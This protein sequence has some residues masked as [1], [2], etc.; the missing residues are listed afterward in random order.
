[1]FAILC[2]LTLF[3]FAD[4]TNRASAEVN[5]DEYS[6]AIG[7]N[8]DINF[9]INPTT[10]VSQGGALNVAK[11]TIIGST[12]APTGYR[13]FLSSASDDNSFLLEG[14]EKNTARDDSKM[15]AT[16][17]TFLAPE[18][19]F[20]SQDTPA[21]WGFAIPGVGSFD[22]VYTTS[23]P[24]V[25]AKFAAV[26]TAGNGQL[27][28][29]TD[30]AIE[31]DSLDIYY[32]TKVNSRLRH[33]K[34]S[35]WVKYSAITDMSSEVVDGISI[36][37]HRVRNNYEPGTAITI[38]SEARIASDLGVLIAT[39]NNQTCGNIKKTSDDP[40]ILT[41]EI[42]EG[43]EN[44]EYD[45][46]LSIPQY[47]KT[48]SSTDKLKIVDP[49]DVMQ[50]I[51]KEVYDSVVTE[52][53]YQF[54]DSRD[55]KKYYITKLKNGNLYMTQNLDFEL[56]TEGTVLDPETSDVETTKTLT[57]NVS[58]SIQYTTSEKKY[59]YTQNLDAEGRQ[60]GLYENNW[61]NS[62]IR[63]TGRETGS[64]Q[65]HVVTIPG[66]A[67]LLIDIY[68]SGEDGY[69]WFGIFKGSHP[70][71]NNPSYTTIDRVIY[72]DVGMHNGTSYIVNGNTLEDVGHTAVVVEGDTAT[73]TFRA[74]SNKVGNGYGYY[75]IISGIM[76][77][78]SNEG[79]PND[80]VYLKV[81][82]DENNEGDHHPFGAL[83]SLSAAITQPVAEDTAQT[84]SICPKG[85]HLDNYA[86]Y[87]NTITGLYGN[88]S[89]GNGTMIMKSSPLFL[90]YG[91]YWGSNY[92]SISLLGNL[93]TTA[94]TAENIYN[95]MIEEGKN[96]VKFIRCV[97]QAPQHY[98]ISFNANGGSNPP[99]E[100]YFGGWESAN[101]HTFVLG[102]SIPMREDGTFKG[103]S[104]NANALTGDYQPGDKFIATGQHT[105][106]AIWG[107]IHNRFDDAFEAAGKTKMNGYYAMQDMTNEICDAVPKLI[108]EYEANTTQLIDLRDNKIYFVSKLADGKCWMTQNLNYELSNSGTTLD[109]STSSVAT[110]RT[111]LPSDFGEDQTYYQNFGNIMVND[112][113]GSVDITNVAT[114]TS[115]PLIHYLVG[116]SYTYPAATALANKTN[117]I[118][119]SSS[120]G[121]EESGD[122]EY[123]P[124][125]PEEPDSFAELKE[126]AVP[127][128]VRKYSHTQNIDDTGRASGNYGNSWNNSYIRGTDRT[129]AN[130]NAHVITI[131][132]ATELNVE[133]YHSG[134]SCCDYVSVYEGSHPTYT[135][136]TSGYKY[137]QAMGTGSNYGSYS[138]N[139]NT[140]NAYHA[141]LTI[142]GDT[143]TFAFRSDSSVNGYGYYAIVT[144][145][146][147]G[148][149]EDEGI[150]NYNPPIDSPVE[151]KPTAISRTQNVDESGIKTTGYSYG[152]DNN[153]IAGTN[154]T[155]NSRPHAVCISN[156]DYLMVDIYYSM[157]SSTYL[158]MLG[159]D[160]SSN[161]SDWDILNDYYGVRGATNING[162]G[163]GTYTI[164]GNSISNL[165]YRRFMV[166]G[167]CVSFMFKSYDNGSNYY[168]Y[169][170]IVYGEKISD[171]TNKKIGTK[172]SY[173]SNL[174]QDGR[175]N[176]NYGDNWGNA[177]ILGSTR[178]DS[179]NAHVVTIPN[180]TKLLVDIFYNTESADKDWVSV[181][182][183][184]QGTY[185]A[186]RNFGNS[187]SGKLGGVQYGNYT[188]KNHT[189]SN[190]GHKQYIISGNSV[191]F[192]FTSNE[193]LS[194]DGYG[195]YAI[196]TGY[197]KN[198]GSSDSVTK[199]A[200]VQES[201][202][203]KGW[204]LPHV[205]NSSNNELS[206]LIP[207][208]NY[209]DAARRR[210][211]V[212]QPLF[213][214][215][216]EAP[217]N[218]INDNSIE[219]LIQTLK[220]T[221]A[222]DNSSLGFVRCIAEETY[223]F[224][225]TFNT[226]DDGAVAPD[227]V[228]A[229][230]TDYSEKTIMIPNQDIS[231]P[232][233]K[234]LG[235]SIDQN[236]ESATYFP[237]T[238]YS[239]DA[240]SIELYAVWQR[241]ETFDEAFEMVGKTKV[242]GE[243]YAMQDMTEQICGLIPAYNGTIITETLIDTRDNKLYTIAKLKDNHCWM[244]Q[245]LAFMTGEGVTLNPSTSDVEKEMSANIAP[246]VNENGFYYTYEA[247]T[248]GFGRGL[249]TMMTGDKLSNIYY[250]NQPGDSMN[251]IC[252]KGWS[253]PS[254]T[255]QGNNYA[256]LINSYLNSGNPSML[257]TDFVPNLNGVIDTST[258][259]TISSM[260]G[261]WT[262]T[263]AQLGKSI[264]VAFT[265]NNPDIAIS[266]RNY[267]MPIR[268]MAVDDSSSIHIRTNLYNLG[269]MQGITPELVAAGGFA[270]DVID[271]RDE[272][273][274]NRPVYTV[275][276]AYDGRAW[277][278][279]SLRYEHEDG[280]I[281][282]PYTSDV[283]EPIAFSAE[284]PNSYYVA[285][286]HN[287]YYAENRTTIDEREIPSYYSGETT[288]RFA[289]VYDYNTSTM[290]Y[291]YTF[292]YA[293]VNNHDGSSICPAGWQLPTSDM[294]SQY[295]GSGYSYMTNGS[296]EGL[297]MDWN[298]M[299]NLGGYYTSPQG[300]E[301][302]D[303][304]HA[305]D[306]GFFWTSTRISNRN[307][308]GMWFSSTQSNA[309]FPMA[310][311]V[312]GQVRCVSK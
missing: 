30:A 235:W 109:P 72:S 163:T 233:H 184:S 28:H 85:W 83:Y 161:S 298:Q 218:Y 197:G 296:S 181:W 63:G 282:D 58:S 130:S 164:N 170:A 47:G 226:N 272:G 120:S 150:Q 9:T 37:P 18:A 124:E 175:K 192:S 132:G 267:A 303:P 95:A 32:G 253:I 75:A 205:V 71:Y 74:D 43:L 293:T 125:D 257:Q 79:E 119:N 146:T 200:V 196:I 182:S 241:I 135:Q 141:T 220:N 144:A 61:N 260:S 207:E 211:F 198:N 243:H 87:N 90:E 247:A 250:I 25:S 88:T 3:P 24:S 289:D 201:V 40:L 154:R 183:G 167:T 52:Q 299:M 160:E 279:T 240:A 2:L 19:L 49:Y 176:A 188:I 1:M 202:C 251:T 254:A 148:S 73:F 128:T 283:P 195:Y 156:V 262:T 127:S 278:T 139:G 56:S 256:G 276:K 41:C 308:R 96:P 187:L 62:H 217:V 53:Q 173:T 38:T 133:L 59:S 108:S 261:Y 126:G 277:M 225:M 66:A 12:N 46:A 92:T 291:Y 149:Y 60:L 263:L 99:E 104:E 57:A 194:G 310:R 193:N 242:D 76:V 252:P 6:L 137:N 236:A 244:I 179:N 102:K 270:E 15:Q 98:S 305:G 229:L 34:Y 20:T 281:L 7:M 248:A 11:T 204:R 105:L 177:N 231:Y 258:N 54:V 234:F 292:D 93:T 307:A 295:V 80:V 82:E 65:G 45:V 172:Y 103:W 189:L 100:Q 228:Y 246:I 190:M 216:T 106:Y 138:L 162:V 280:A 232:G 97:Y 165:N 212:E 171:S 199:Q 51:D 245:D 118:F 239:F 8:G 21:T 39:V 210:Y 215:D 300:D 36:Y 297:R 69:D 153:N 221:Y 288:G 208:G 116:S 306:E 304:E 67:A 227:N 290:G 22:D 312:A 174:D 122:H 219:P 147:I 166:T 42:P 111:I 311:N 114:S 68:H 223:P 230:F 178:G 157:G 151:S 271:E 134:E 44:G 27:I 131:P 287:K 142:R 23:A 286:P 185:T 140:I 273:K 112:F 302:S 284:G 266:P 168:G 249:K 26:P 48:F 35:A 14:E 55:N 301:Y 94:S 268:C 29:E 269:T 110:S 17:G 121:T 10:E 70:S 145:N 129:S 275:Y 264:N 237:G 86:D 309:S 33:G 259:E 222:H 180:A 294:M 152:W 224:A 159:G 209:T 5:G 78:E 191:T 206:K 238:Y 265:N 77:A 16:T 50:E 158:S 31:N 214:T 285:T 143:V 186:Q 13:L 91:G 213:Y 81:N 203:P 101:T 4:S 255:A 89:R 155:S 64:T 115:D 274:E 123:I 84:E 117:A 136:G 113:Y 107:D 169:Y